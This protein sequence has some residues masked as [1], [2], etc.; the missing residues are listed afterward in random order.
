MLFYQIGELVSEL[1][2]RKKAR[3]SIASLMDI[4]PDFANVERDG[5][6]S[7]RWIPRRYSR[8]TALCCPAGR[9]DSAGWNGPG[10]CVRSQYKR[11]HGG[12]SLPRDVVPGSDVISG[13]V[14]LSGLLRI[15]VTKPFEE[16]TVNRILE[17]VENSSLK[18]SKTENFITRFCPLLYAY[19]LHWEQC[20]LLFFRRYF[21]ETGRNGSAVH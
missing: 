15:R 4:R 16:S 14:N 3:R 21:W 7:F 5:G 6:R 11:S 1:C 8:A 17:L 13:C 12:E 10:R 20:C 9:A 18:K 19:C 2:R